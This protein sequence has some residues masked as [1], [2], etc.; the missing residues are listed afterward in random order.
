VDINLFYNQWDASYTWGP[1]PKRFGPPPS[2]S[3]QNELRG[4]SLTAR[5]PVRTGIPK[6]SKNDQQM[7]WGPTIEGSPGRD[8]KATMVCRD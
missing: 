2:N 6:K 5:P 8:E 1:T 4:Y 7:S 3:R